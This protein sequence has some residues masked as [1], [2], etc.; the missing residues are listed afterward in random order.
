[1]R[2]SLKKALCQETIQE[3]PR[4]DPSAPVNREEEVRLYD[5]YGRPKYWL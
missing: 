3:G 2:R 4:Y 5:Y 1:M